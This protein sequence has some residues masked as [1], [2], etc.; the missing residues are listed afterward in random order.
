[1]MVSGIYIIYSNSDSCKIYVGSAFNLSHR[2]QRHFNDLHRNR[3]HNQKMQ[4]HANKYGI[5]DL[6][7]QVLEECSTSQLI[8]RE[9]FYIDLFKPFFNINPVA[10]SRAG[11]K[12]TPGQRNKIRNSWRHRPPI[13]KTKLFLLN[14]YR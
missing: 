10:G 4:H 9:Q 12:L 14:L 6:I 11:A 1:M 2:Q 7:F 13:S 5:H 3:H 8:S